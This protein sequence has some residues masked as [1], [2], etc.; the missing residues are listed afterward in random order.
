MSAPRP[1]SRRI[2]ELDLLR[3]FFI[4]VVIVDHLQRWPSPFTYIT[5]EGR[6]WVSA[7]EGFFLIS[8]LLIG[9]LRVYKNRQE[10]MKS[11]AVKLLKRAAMLY[12]WGVG[13]TFFVVAGTAWLST[14]ATAALF[15]KLPDAGQIS[16]LGTYLVSVFST[17]YSSDWIYF[18]RLYAI[19]LA[20]TPLVVWLLRK[21][22]WWLVLGLSLA[23]YLAAYVLKLEE[24][25][26][27]WQV[28]FFGAA[29]IGAQLEK[30]LSFLR[31][32][33]TLRTTLLW[34]LIG[35]TLT[36]MVLSY[37]FVHGWDLVESGNFFM[38][39]ETYVS[40]RAVIDPWFVN[41]PVIAPGRM[42]LAFVWFGGLLALFHV[43]RR[44]LQRWLGWLLLRFGSY[45][46]SMYCLQA[47]VL[48]GLQWLLPLTTS[49][50]IN[51]L[52]A[53]AVVLAIWGLSYV[54]LVRR[55]LPR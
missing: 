21:G 36:T 31:H 34:S 29:L 37:F 20:L 35:V 2:I 6:L 30:I 8:G 23:L 48:V 55:V 12:A 44:A 26:L 47:I 27:Q 42:L 41:T 17:A 5:G 54:P 19:M 46:L 32:H 33:M 1:T 24:A 53:V 15:P 9:Y 14:D 11:L 22:L 4:L 40:I 45:S 49:Q 39:R 13:I 51:T 3:G 28:L 7:A 50:W 25:A 16:S 43:L 52:Y 38:S 18:L 10:S